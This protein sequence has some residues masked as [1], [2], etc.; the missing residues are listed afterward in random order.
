MG[1]AKRTKKELF[2]KDPDQFVNK[3]DLYISIGKEGTIINSSLPR[4]LTISAMYDL[5][6]HF[7]EYIEYMDAESAKAKASSIITPGNNGK[8]RF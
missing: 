1:E 3:A 2:K 7:K 8:K 4:M 6:R 5:K